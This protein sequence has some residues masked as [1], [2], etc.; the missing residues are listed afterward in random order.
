MRVFKGGKWGSAPLSLAPSL[1]PSRT[2]RSTQHP[3][4][5]GHFG[6]REEEATGWML[7]PRTQG[8]VWLS[9]QKKPHLQRLRGVLQ[10]HGE[11]SL[12][13]AGAVGRAEGVFFLDHLCIP[14]APLHAWSI[15]GARCK[16]GAEQ[17]HGQCPAGCAM[18]QLPWTA[19]EVL[20][21]TPWMSC[22]SDQKG[23]HS[24]AVWQKYLT[25]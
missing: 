23:R 22:T 19:T 7:F 13:K 15:P 12:R 8:D 2:P 24:T 17:N 11:E 1:L 3:L 14:T 25:M 20:R 6:H 10:S 5:P 16:L 21:G 9:R 4:C 18:T